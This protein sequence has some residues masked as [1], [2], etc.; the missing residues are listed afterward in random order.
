[1]TEPRIFLVDDQPAVLKALARLLKA[2]GFEVVTFDSAQAFLDSGNATQPG[3]L[4]LDLSMPGM[5]GLA[6]QQAL[7]QCASLLPLIF[8]TGHGDLQSGIHAMKLGAADFLTKP[9]DEARLISAVQLALASN[10]R[11]RQEHL[12]RELIMQRLASLTPREREVL[13]LLIEGWLNKQVAAE[14]GT[15][16]K[17]I[18]VHRAHVMA[19]MQVRSLTQLVRMVDLVRHSRHPTTNPI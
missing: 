10:L 9:V 15:V 13:D 4:I 11:Q 8:L 12:E 18:K 6:L 19:K 7:S 5:N 1:M 3:C 16:E 2:A 14:L 17:T